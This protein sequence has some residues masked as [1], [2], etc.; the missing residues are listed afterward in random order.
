MHRHLTR[1]IA[2]RTLYGWRAFAFA[3]VLTGACF[4]LVLL[5][6]PDQRGM[7]S[8]IALMPAFILVPLVAGWRASLLAAALCV[9]GSWFV[10]TPDG[11]S[12]VLRITTALATGVTA[13]VVSGTL[14]FMQQV[15][16]DAQNARRELS[17][18][19]QNLFAVTQ[20]LVRLSK[21]FHPNDAERVLEDVTD[22]IDA[23]ARANSVIQISPLAD[24]FPLSDFLE[25]LLLPYRLD[26]QDRLRTRGPDVQIN[27]TL[28][29]PLG[30]FLH[31]LATNAVKH[32]ALGTMGGSLAVTWSLEERKGGES[33]HLSWVETMPDSITLDTS[34][35]EHLGAVILRTSAEQLKASFTHEL[36]P[37]GLVAQ[38]GFKL[39]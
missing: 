2:T 4:T 26:A 25:N 27:T 37:N 19:V 29:T 23:L 8:T 21:R 12:L 9:I 24:E 22:R 17:H 36:R 31:E 39:T 10:L 18:R 30:L 38:L 14:S 20:S 7:F 28:M 32:G 35:P 11:A 15:L 6:A 5:F 3:A 33:L 1:L 13:L 16:E 34:G